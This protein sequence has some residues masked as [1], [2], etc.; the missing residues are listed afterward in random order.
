MKISNNKFLAIISAI[1]I[2]VALIL[3]I[4]Q[5]FFSNKKDQEQKPIQ[6]KTTTNEN[7]PISVDKDEY[8]EEAKDDLIRLSSPLKEQ[9]VE[10]PL[11]IKGEA[12][13]TWFFEGSFPIVLTDWDGK[14]IAETTAKAEGDWMTEN[15]VPFSAELN[16]TPDTKVSNRGS[17]ILRKDNPSGLAQNDNALEI[18]VLFAK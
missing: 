5:H 14:I 17:L 7:K 1:I 4:N 12:R 6:E 18:T 11:M 3:Y 2:L 10:S 9:I 15:Y 16:F 13:G 8:R